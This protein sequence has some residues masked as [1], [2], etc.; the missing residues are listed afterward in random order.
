MKRLRS[1][2]I[3]GIAMQAQSL[4]IAELA[5]NGGDRRKLLHVSEFRFPDGLGLGKP[6]ELG[7]ALAQHLR[8]HNISAK[9]V[10]IGLP[11]KWLVTRR[12][13]LPPSSPE[14]AAA[15]LRL[16]AEA[17]IASDSLAMDYAG[18]SNPSRACSVLLVATSSDHLEPCQAMIKAAG[19]RLHSATATGV[20]LAET[21]ASDTGRSIFVNLAGPGAELIAKGGGNPIL[22]S[23]VTLTEGEDREAALA[24][25]IRRAIAGLPGQENTELLLCAADDAAAPALADRLQARL[26]MPARVATIKHL[27][28]AE[29][30]ATGAFMPA[31]ALALSSL[32]SSR[33]HIDFLHSRLIVPRTRMSR[34]PYVWAAGIA[35]TLFLAGVIAS[36]D[37]K[38]RQNALAMKQQ[39]VSST[40]DGVA[41]AQAAAERLAFARNWSKAEPRFLTCLAELTRLFPDEGTIWATNMSLRENM[42]GQISGKAT[43]SQEILSLLD[44]MKDDRRFASPKLLDLRESAAAG[45]EVAFII[46]FQFRPVEQ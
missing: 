14:A 25:E 43:G 18:A 27:L 9:D 33:P 19:L 30:V 24:S 7:R 29:D 2:K 13:D 16:Q 42:A 38:S 46:A 10:T 36:V 31:I 3:L 32:D 22:L 21:A 40:A 4:S 15:S 5:V 11:A 34:R 20:A 1:N 37:L 6:V 45:R 17:E 41:A 23:H 44:R 8:R 26:S 12:K 35:A 28:H 39:K